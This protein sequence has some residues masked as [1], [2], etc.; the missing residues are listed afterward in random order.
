MKL[1]IVNETDRPY[2]RHIAEQRSDGLLYY[3]HPDLKDWKG[4]TAERATPLE[5]FSVYC[6]VT[7]GILHGH[8]EGESRAEYSTGEHRPWQ[9]SDTFSFPVKIAKKLRKVGINLKK[10]HEAFQDY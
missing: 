1:F 10:A 2:E 4:M 8:R 3:L 7:D 6:K 5:D 9:G